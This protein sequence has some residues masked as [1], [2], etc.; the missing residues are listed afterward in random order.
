MSLLTNTFSRYM[1]TQKEVEFV[2]ED[3]E[4]EES[5]PE[6]KTKKSPKK[7]NM[8]KFHFFPYFFYGIF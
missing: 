7:V 4:E 5:K 8:E 1:V 2:S 3:E 6:P